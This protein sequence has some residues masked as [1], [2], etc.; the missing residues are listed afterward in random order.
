MW[1]DECQSPCDTCEH[2]ACETVCPKCRWRDA[3][4]GLRRLPVDNELA[5]H[6]RMLVGLT[7]RVAK[8]A[9]QLQRL[10]VFADEI[11]RADLNERLTKIEEVVP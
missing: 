10:E 6:E 11:A 1:K 8:L 4:E 3:R 9:Q 7:G 5:R 2:N